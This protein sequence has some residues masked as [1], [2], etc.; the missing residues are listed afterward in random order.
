MFVIAGVSGH[1]GSVVAK[2]LLAAGEK[3]K[4]LVRDAK[5]GEPWAEQGAQVAT[6]SLDDS[7][8]VAGALKG[9]EGFFTLLPPPPFTVPDF[10]AAQRATADAL[11]AG[12]KGS[13]VP[14]VVLLSS[15][16]AD[17]AEGTGP[18]KG[19]HYFEGLLHAAGVQLSAI[20]AGYF[21]ENVGM[22]VAPAKGAGIYPNFAPSADLAMPMIATKDIGALAAKLLVER[23]AKSENVDLHGPAYSANEVAAKLGAVLGKALNV[24]TI[25][26]AGHLPALLEAGLP[27]TFAAAY[28]EM[29]AGF[30]TGNVG[31]KGDRLVQGVTPLD[32]V[33]PSLVSLVS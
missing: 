23:P 24:V 21:Q 31:P 4:V 28:A 33:L 16:G 19:L 13:G 25:P 9:A 26:Q 14:H 11:A 7:A 30:A 8:F 1:V 20:R 12:V 32:E 2:S 15:V 3:V 6:G 5:K 27:P 18:I 29:Y 10:F 17:L 22:S